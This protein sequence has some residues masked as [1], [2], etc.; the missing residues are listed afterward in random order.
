MVSEI[1]ATRMGVLNRWFADGARLNTDLAV[2]RAEVIR[3][4]RK[5]LRR[6]G[7][8]LEEMATIFGV[9]M[10]YAT[11][12]AYSDDVIARKDEYIAAFLAGLELYL[13]NNEDLSERLNN[14]FKRVMED[15]KAVKRLRYTVALQKVGIPVSEKQAEM[16]AES[17][18]P[19][20]DEQGI[21]IDAYG[22][23]LAAFQKRCMTAAWESGDTLENFKVLKEAL[24]HKK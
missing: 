19:Y 16:L 11:L 17:I 24:K 18:V 15:T 3:I 2:K 12:N 21:E 6:E 22:V 7:F 9:I 5:I 23:E 20:L 8:T 4:S 14:A 1:V 10:G 13:P